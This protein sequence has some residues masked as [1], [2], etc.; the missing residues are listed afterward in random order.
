[1]ELSLIVSENNSAKQVDWWKLTLAFLLCLTD[2]NIYQVKS[3]KYNLQRSFWE[4]VACFV[5]L[6]VFA[7]IHKG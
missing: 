2:H 7:F 5:T 1:M 6:L 4:I 3:I